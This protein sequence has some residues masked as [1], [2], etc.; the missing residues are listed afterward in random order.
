MKHFF[1]LFSFLIVFTSAAKAALV[2]SHDNADGSVALGG[3]TILFDKKEAS[4]VATVASL[5]ADDYRLV[6]GKVLKVSDKA[7]KNDLIIV[8]TSESAHIKTLVKK[9]LIDVSPIANGFE[10]YIIAIVDN[11]FRKGTDALVVVGSD[12]R[13]AAYGLLSVS[14]AMGVSPWHWWADVPVA[15]HDEVYVSG[16]VVSEKPS[17]RYRGI[18]INDEDWGLTPWA[19][20]TYEPE[21]GNIG[22]RTYARVCELLLRLRANMLAPA[23]HTCSDAFYVHA[24]NKKVA[25]KYGIMI[26]TS[27]CEPLLFNNASKAEWDSAKDGDWN[28]KTNRDVIYNKLD[29]RVK[30]A[31]PYDNIYTMAMRG[32]H[33]EGMRGDMPLSE[34]VQV[35]H[36]AIMDQREILSKHISKPVETIPQIFVP[37]KEA[38]HLYEAG[39]E[40]PEDIT[41]V[42]PDDN[43]GYMKMLSNPRDRKRS[44]RAGVYYHVSYLGVPHSYLWISTTPPMLIYEEMKK[45]YDTG[46]DR[47]WLL[48]VGDIKPMELTMQFFFQMAWD[49]HQ[50]N[51]NNV[52]SYQANFLAG[53][54]GQEYRHDFQSMLDEYYRL[55]WSRKPEAMG[56]ERE[57]DSPEFTG[58]RDTEF[59]FSNYNDAQTRLVEYNALAN[60]AEAIL[61]SLPENLRPAF[62]EMIGYQALGSN[63]MNRK[64]LLSQLNHELAADGDMAGANQA[65]EMA[66]A[67]ND[68]IN[69]L[70]HIY[71]TMLDGKWN[72]MMTI[73]PAICALN[74][75]MPKLTTDASAGKR[76]IDLAPNQAE[77]NLE[78]SLYIPVEA[79]SNLTGGETHSFRML[80]GMGYDWKAL[81]L[82]EVTQPS[83]DPANASAPRVTY[84]LPAIDADSITVVLYTLPRFP[85]YKGAN[86]AF[87]VSVDNSPVEISNFI[88]VEQSREW[89]DNVIRNAMITK[90]KF[91]IEKSQRGHKLNI[92]SGDPGLIVQRILI[93]WGGLKK[94]YV[95]PDRK[96]K[97]I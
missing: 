33:D 96:S 13:G 43:Y 55:A 73:S 24:D 42:W 29:N 14:E 27:H 41:L 7:D 74:H 44:G 83:C 37:Y 11:P 57:W 60:K 81:M 92:I 26:T 71:N 87:G 95:G 45:A 69:A 4:V 38:Q 28:Y 6:T 63:Q 68:S 12:P 5:F 47:Y 67:A 40:V 64:F 2:V 31:A 21:V 3:R 18:F 36:N 66:L 56:W 23:M 51:Y 97:N 53:I 32:L 82:G 25:D 61:E 79:F 48:N 80:E 65:A 49:F 91:P 9:G 22:P 17:V 70:N 78:N 34:K 76:A 94:T 88:P 8:G 20:K 77:Y 72:H 89:K 16:S 10:R 15:H 75:L 86:T 90:M 52:N 1:I 54:F 62:F 19:A 30:E 39:L 59:S 84:D 50:F 93:D 46:A 85:L 35:L 58:L